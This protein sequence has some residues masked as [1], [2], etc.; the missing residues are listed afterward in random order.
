MIDPQQIGCRNM[1]TT[2]NSTST[3]SD[4]PG[5]TVVATMR[6]L[7]G[8]EEAMREVL[9][10]LVEPTRTHDGV[11]E[12]L[13]HRGSRDPGMFCFYERWT[14]DAALDAHLE[15]PPL[16]ALGGRLDGLLDGEIT[17][18]RLHRIA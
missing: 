9:E 8:R 14:D 12:Y 11:V 10:S 15:T 6:A 13:L 2:T 1:T 4:G 5:L 16:L 7:P 18:H 3:H 17:I